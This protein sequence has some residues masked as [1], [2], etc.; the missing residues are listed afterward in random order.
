MSIEK[1]IVGIQKRSP[2]E[3]KTMRE[4]ALK[5]LESG[6]HGK[7]SDATRL[8]A[9]LD[10]QEGLEGDQRTAAAGKLAKGPLVDRIAAAFTHDPPAET[11][12][13]LI[14][15][16]LDNP[17]SSCAQLSVKIGWAPTTWDM[18]FG[19]VC[20]KRADFLRELS[21]TVVQGQ[22]KNLQLLTPTTRGEDGTILYSMKP[23]AVAGFK[24]VGFPVNIG[25]YPDQ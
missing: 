25:L 22:S 6:D 2:Q 7:I 10:A 24:S 20:A 16:L 15:V 12:R 14:Q 4:H 17:N 23:E 8:I 13:K 1:I 18:G 3:R 9:A 5:W 21:D 11:E 19:S